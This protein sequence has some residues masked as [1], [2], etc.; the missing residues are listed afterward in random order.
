MLTGSYRKRLEAD[1]TRWVGEGL[2]TAESAVA[3]RRSVAA[4]GGFRL[5]ALLGLFGGLLI[6]ASIAAFVATFITASVVAF[7]SASITASVVAFAS[8]SVTTS[9]GGGGLSGA[10][11]VRIILLHAGGEGEAGN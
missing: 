1:L 9:I 8:A 5:P 3:I 2:L 10:F 6:A 4:E 11:A 7:A